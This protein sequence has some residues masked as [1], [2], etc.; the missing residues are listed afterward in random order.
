M[1]ERKRIIQYDPTYMEMCCEA[2]SEQKICKV[3]PLVFFKEM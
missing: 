1:S 3:L 2:S